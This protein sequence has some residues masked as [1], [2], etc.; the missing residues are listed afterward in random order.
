VTLAQMGAS[1]NVRLVHV[2]HGK[3][4]HAEPIALLYEQGR[5]IHC[6]SLVALEEELLALGVGGER[7]AP[8]S[9]SCAGVGADGADAGRIGAADQT[10]VSA[11]FRLASGRARQDRRLRKASKMRAI[12]CVCAAM[13]AAMAPMTAGAKPR[14]TDHSAHVVQLGD[15]NEALVRQRGGGNVANLRQL[16]DDNAACLVQSGRGLSL[17]VTQTG[18]ESLSLMQTRG[19]THAL[20]AQACRAIAGQRT[21]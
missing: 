9:R 8:G 10:A 5:V 12:V 20:P 11:R 14:S 18:G 21:R 6:G 13:A 15:G 7:R 3:R 17:E 19:N 2:A 4:V 16:G 1:C